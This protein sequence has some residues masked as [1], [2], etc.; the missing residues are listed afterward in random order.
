MSYNVKLTKQRSYVTV[1]NVKTF[2]VEH[3]AQGGSFGKQFSMWNVGS[4][5]IYDVRLI[6]CYLS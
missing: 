1:I 6:L 5:I 2:K 3:I 4:L